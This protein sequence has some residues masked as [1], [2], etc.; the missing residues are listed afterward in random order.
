MARGDTTSRARSTG[1]GL[2][3]RVVET[4][5]EAR[6]A[7]V[8]ARQCGQEILLVTAPGACARLGPG[9]LLEMMRQA[10]AGTPSVRALIDSSPSSAWPQADAGCK[11]KSAMLALRLGWR[12]I[13]LKGEPSIVARIAATAGGSQ[14][15]SLQGDHRRAPRGVSEAVGEAAVRHDQERACGGTFHHELPGADATR[16]SNRRVKRLSRGS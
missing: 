4:L 10:G 9:Y 16:S 3:P 5:E 6:T 11:C 12:D 1:G 7:V 15:G 8:D 13:H 2:T 14:A